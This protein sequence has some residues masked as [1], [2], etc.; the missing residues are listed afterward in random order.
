MKM[1][2]CKQCGQVVPSDFGQAM[3]WRDPAR[4]VQSEHDYKRLYAVV[5]LLAVRR[6]FTVMEIRSRG[7]SHELTA[8]RIAIARVLRQEH[9][10]SYPQIGGLLHHDHT[11]VLRWFRPV[12]QLNRG[13]DACN[14]NNAVAPAV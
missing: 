2:I 12:V 1:H 3:S 13:K 4:W 14:D 11:T 5:E 10:L 6:G 8:A 7:K 9:E